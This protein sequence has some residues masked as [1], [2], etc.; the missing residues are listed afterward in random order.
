MAEQDSDLPAA[1]GVRR[2]HWDGANK[3]RIVE[4]RLRCHRQVGA[5]DR[6]AAAVPE[7]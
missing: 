6:L 7:R 2:R 4:D 1:D 3:V 5:T